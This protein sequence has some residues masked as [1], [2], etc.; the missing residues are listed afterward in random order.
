MSDPASTVN[1]TFESPARTSRPR[2]SSRH[3]RDLEG[4]PE[5]TAQQMARD[6]TA[7]QHEPSACDEKKLY[8]YR[9]SGQKEPSDDEV[10]V[11]LDFGEIVA[12]EVNRKRKVSAR[13]PRLTSVQNSTAA[14]S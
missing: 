7:Y 10:F 12:L 1:I 4:V 3:R 8:K 9:P 6:F 2:S 13:E 5:S 11:A 14:S